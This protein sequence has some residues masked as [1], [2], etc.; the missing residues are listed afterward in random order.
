MMSREGHE[1]RHVSK[2]IA[3]H[4]GG[5][6]RML[7]CGSSEDVTGHFL[8]SCDIDVAEIV[9]PLI[10]KGEF[11]HVIPDIDVEDSVNRRFPHKRIEHV[12]PP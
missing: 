7:L 5:G 1:G 11:V 6:H 3:A 4:P 12:R 2:A 9:K 10:D 8:K